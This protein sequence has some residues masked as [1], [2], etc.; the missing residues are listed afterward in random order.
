[1]STQ[2]EASGVVR[3]AVAQ[4]SPGADVQENIAA[5]AELIAA[6]DADMVVLPE[7]SLYYSAPFGPETATHAITPEGPEIAAIAALARAHDRWIV[8]GALEAGEG[9]PFNTVFALDNRGE[10]R[11]RYRKQHLYDAFGVTESEW[12]APG[13][14][15]ESEVFTVGGLRCA[16]QTCYDIRF[17]EVSRALVD[18]GAE[19]LLIPAQWVP[20][21]LKESHWST[22]LAAR[23]IENTVY[24]VAADHAA[25]HGVGLSRIL[26]P[27]GASIAAVP[28][29]T[30]TAVGTLSA[31]EITRVRRVNPALELRRYRVQPRD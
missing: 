19:V 26:D 17:P 20:G 28:T 24:V 6:A 23:A 9:R 29:G 16:L 12:I 21:P 11:A 31:A 25:P 4:F 7:Y 30:G 1:M 10:L 18:A 27:A 15:G 13:P 3:V 2:Q 5:I 14:L 8:L 22:L